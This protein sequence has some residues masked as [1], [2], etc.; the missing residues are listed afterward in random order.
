MIVPLGPQI[1]W[2]FFQALTNLTPTLLLISQIR[3]LI[4]TKLFLTEGKMNLLLLIT[5]Y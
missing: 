3:E 2:L 5:Q 1:Y 4:F